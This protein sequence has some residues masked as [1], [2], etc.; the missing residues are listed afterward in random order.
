[1]WIRRH[2]FGSENIITRV[3]RE[4]NDPLLFP[5]QARRV[6]IYSKTDDMVDWETVEEHALEAEE[7]GVIVEKEMFDKS[8]HVGHLMADPLRYRKI[9]EGF[10]RNL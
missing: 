4:L 7:D 1:M 10:V 6:Y 8:K 3:R 5:T 9:L 2:V